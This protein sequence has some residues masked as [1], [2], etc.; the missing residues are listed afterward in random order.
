MV[1]HQGTRYRWL[2]PVCTLSLLWMF[3]PGCAGPSLK[4]APQVAAL[5]EA[6][7]TKNAQLQAQRQQRL[8]QRIKELQVVK[9]DPPDHFRVSVDLTD[10]ALPVV[11]RRTL[12][13]TGISYVFDDAVL[14]GTVTAQFQN[15]P[16]QQALNLL[17]APRGL[18]VVWQDSGLVISSAAAA[19]QMHSPPTKPPDSAKEK[20]APAPS[21]SMYLELPMQYLDMETVGKFLS[22]LYPKNDERDT[23]LF[24]GLQIHTNTVFLRGSREQVTQAATLLR[25][26]DHEPAHVV[27]EALVV[28]FKASEIEQLGIDITNLTSGNLSNVVTNFGSLVTPAATFTFTRGAINI[29]ELSALIQALIAQDYAHLVARPYVSTLSGKEATATITRNQFIVVDK[30]EDGAAVTALEPIEA[31]VTLK[32]T[33]TIMP[34][35]TIRMIIDVEDSQFV[36]TGA[37]APGDITTEVEKSVATTVMQVENGTT[38][39]IGGLT[40]HQVSR[41]NAGFPWLRRVPPFSW[42][43]GNQAELMSN[44]EVVIYVTPYIWKPGLESPLPAPETFAVP[45]NQGGPSRLERLGIP[46]SLDHK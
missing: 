33:P 20:A 46:S 32:I 42:L 7:Q 6:Y 10:A 3:L 18:A 40:R 8:S 27:I 29:T 21:A 38:I 19:D 17:L 11:V 24:Y 44:D 5:L 30:P 15:V 13:T 41:G 26:A 39:I 22:G 35:D 43:F 16:L 34:R 23:S 12:E 25:A 31:G 14:T 1:V 36:V 4:K 2:P 45:E 28:Q 37:S 9:A